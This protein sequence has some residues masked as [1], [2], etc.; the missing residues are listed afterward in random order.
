VCLEGRALQTTKNRV[1]LRI[2]YRAL[3]SVFLKMVGVAFLS[4]VVCVVRTRDNCPPQFVHFGS[5]IVL[6]IYH[7]YYYIKPSIACPTV[8][9][10]FL[11]N[12]KI[13]L[14]MALY[15]LFASHFTTYDDVQV[16]ITNPTHFISNRLNPW[17]IACMI[18]VFLFDTDSRL[19]KAIGHNARKNHLHM[20]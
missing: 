11:G 4:Y 18:G 6:Q 8:S 12:W 20:L 16:I 3:T 13:C 15:G 2:C 7:H 1:R 10:Q 19:E 17:L 14:L 9:E 5:A